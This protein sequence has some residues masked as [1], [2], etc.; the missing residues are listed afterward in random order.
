MAGETRQLKPGNYG[1]R[2][3]S[4]RPGTR[5]NMAGIF[6]GIITRRAIRRGTFPSVKDLVTAIGRFTGA[7]NDRCQLFTW[8]KDAGRIAWQNQT[9]KN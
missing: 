1:S 8:T 3:T 2:G 5:L 7:C 4:R 9:I 6:F